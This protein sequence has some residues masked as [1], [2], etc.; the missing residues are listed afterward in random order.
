MMGNLDLHEF[1]VESCAIEGITR[2]EGEA[3]REAE[4]LRSFLST[5]TLIPRHVAWLAG[6][7]EPGARLRSEEG[8]EVVV[9]HHLAPPGGPA[10]VDM[11]EGILLA[12]RANTPFWVYCAFES[13][14]PLTDGNGRTGRAV[15]LWAMMRQEGGLDGSFLEVFH[16]Q[17]LAHMDGS[18]GWA[19]V[20]A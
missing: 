9:G 8:M 3:Q 1:Q 16:R 10:L 18:F 19:R 5:P 4:A 2:S 12:A 15:W 11:L 6:E 7:F 20:A 13:L 17:A 14:H